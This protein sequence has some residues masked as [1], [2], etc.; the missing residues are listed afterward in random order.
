MP[1]RP[2]FDPIK[3][4]VIRN[5]LT[6]ATEEMAA[7]LRRSAYSTNVKTRQD[8]SCAFFDRDLRPIAQAFTQPVHLGSFVKHVPTAVRRYTG[9]EAPSLEGWGAVLSV[10]KGSESRLP[11]RLRE[12]GPG[13]MVLSNDPYG[14]GVHLNDITLIGAVYY[15]PNGPARSPSLRSG[16]S[17][18]A[19]HL[20]PALIG[21][22][23]CLA[24]HVDVGG[25]APASI[26]A[27]QEIYQEGVI[28]PPVRFVRAGE[29]VPDVFRL[30]LAQI[31]S[32]RETAGDF[33]AQVA[34]NKTGAKRISEIIERYGLDEFNRYTD[35]IVEYTRRRTRAEVAKLPRGVFRAEGTVDTDGY[36]P[37]PV[38]LKVEVRIDASGVT[39]DTT[40]SDQQR[41]AP[42]N[43][44][45]AQ[46]FSACAYALRA[47]MDKDL[48][49][50]Q[51]FYEFVRVIAPEGSVTN[52]RHPAPVV[53]GWE[54]HV[55][56]ND[57]IFKALS[58]PLPDLICAGTK[59]MQ[60]HAGFGGLRFR[61]RGPATA[62]IP[63]PWEG[64]PSTL[65]RAQD[66]AGSGQ[67]GQGGGRSRANTSE[68]GPVSDPPEYYCFLETLAG[69]YGARSRSDGP[70]AVQTHG[71]NTENAPVEETE[72]NYP[73]R[74]VRYGLI[75]DSEGAGRF[76]GGLGLQ[77]DYEFP[78]AATFTVL[79]DRDK[80]GPHGLFGGLPGSVSRYILFPAGGAPA[81]DLSSKTTVQLQ[82]GD[83]ISYRTSGGGGF[84]PPR[85]RDPRLVLRDV[86]EGKISP[87]RAHTVYGV[88]GELAGRA[89]EKARG[90]R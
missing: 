81:R 66:G 76:R 15:P 49:V 2:S 53:G 78:E 65:R 59:A 22:T 54:T 32:K 71:Q 88:S 14:G 72:S 80:A 48:P 21:Y 25:G 46:T 56:L 16:R 7:A 84:G 30:I 23:A 29:I 28:I 44:T 31:R 42:V 11:A 67:R 8:F 89:K 33:R 62:A 87:E 1:S 10:S 9:L 26:G 75:P 37:D 24:H 6:Q 50:N 3:F 20:Q 60:C 77:R 38:R 74:I 63:S 17:A 79:A 5:A 45:F 36:T 13:D 35:E 19:E 52:C 27:F 70:D 39:F 69:G 73:V 85:D 12:F 82:P 61:R 18:P 40:G 43:S 34:A 51:G 41:R 64:D 68:G 57:L 83:A 58:G 90:R 47:L 55:R 86:R 4:E